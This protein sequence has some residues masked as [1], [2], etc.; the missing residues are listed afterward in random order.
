ML[1]REPLSD[2]QSILDTAESLI[3]LGVV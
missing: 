3:R 1:G 2:E